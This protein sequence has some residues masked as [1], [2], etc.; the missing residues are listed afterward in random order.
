MD[1]ILILIMKKLISCYVASILH[2]ALVVTLYF[3]Q[4]LNVVTQY[5][6]CSYK[7]VYVNIIELDAAVQATSHLALDIWSD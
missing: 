2:P 3:V 1:K 4:Y 7:F 6:T 5:N